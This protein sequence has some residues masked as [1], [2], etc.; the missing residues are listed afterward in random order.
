M[1]A[2]KDYHDREE[3]TVLKYSCDEG[4]TWYNF[5]FVD[6]SHLS[7]ENIVRDKIPLAP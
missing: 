6:V 1:V 5:T 7:V 2:A 3:S 4:Y